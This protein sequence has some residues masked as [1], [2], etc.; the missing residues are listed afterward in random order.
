MRDNTSRRN[1]DSRGEKEKKIA[2]KEKSF[3]SSVYLFRALRLERLTRREIEE[4]NARN[5][6]YQEEHRRNYLITMMESEP[7]QMSNVKTTCQL[8][9]SRTTCAVC[10]A[11]AIGMVFVDVFL[12]T[13]NLTPLV[14]LFFRRTKLRCN[15]VFI[16]QRY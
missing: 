9:H 8:M 7:S 5:V 2:E 16:V 6:F 1:V 4:E 3:I 12:F 11:P 15:D 13:K 10:G 14:L